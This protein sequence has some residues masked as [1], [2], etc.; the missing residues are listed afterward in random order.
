MSIPD[1]ETLMLPILKLLSDEKSRKT[2]ELV[3]SMIKEFNISPEDAKELIPSGRAKLINNRVGWACTYLRKAGLIESPQRAI[4]K[5]TDEGI[6]ALKNE[7]IKIDNKFLL[8]FEKFQE[9]RNDRS[10]NID[11]S[12][13]QNIAIEEKTPEE[14]IGIQSQIINKSVGRDLLDI[15]T[16]IE[17]EAFEQLVVDLLLA[18]G[19][20]GTVED[21]GSAIGKTNDG[22]IDGVIKE[23]VL[24]LDT[25]F[26]QAKRWKGTI[27]IKEVRD[28]AGALL[29]KRSNKGVFITTSNFPDGAYDFVEKIDRKIIL[30]DGIR[31]SNLMIKYNLGVS[32]KETIEI[33]EIDTDYFTT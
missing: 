13:E 33:K 3:N 5:I 18:M 4:N 11:K 19:Y 32:V 29:S 16:G 26:I 31:L 28:F 9:F 30:V 12:K 7:P 21:A 1:Y 2:S 22:G 25:I 10:E 27:P 17:P 8:K 20:G 6:K 15:I 23:D 14:I 24:G